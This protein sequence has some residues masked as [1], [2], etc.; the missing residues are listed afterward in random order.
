MLAFAL[1]KREKEALENHF[2]VKHT[3]KVH[4]AGMILMDDVRMKLEELL[5]TDKVLVVPSSRHEVI[6]VKY[7]QEA[8]WMFR[9]MLREVNKLMVTRKDKLSDDVMVLD[10]HTGTLRI[11]K[12]NKGGNEHDN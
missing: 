6:V 12:E 4:G 10:L 7:S 1:S 5:N 11:C 8:E 2:I 9:E 3:N